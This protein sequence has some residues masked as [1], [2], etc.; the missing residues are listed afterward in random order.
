MKEAFWTTETSPPYRIQPD[1][2]DPQKREL[3]SKVDTL[4]TNKRFDYTFRFDTSTAHLTLVVQDMFLGNLRLQLDTLLFSK[5]VSVSPGGSIAYNLLCR[6]H[7]VN[8]PVNNQ[9]LLLQME[10]DDGKNT[11]PL[12]TLRLRD[13]LA[14]NNGQYHTLAQTIPMSHLQGKQG[15]LRVKF[16]ELRPVISNMVVRPPS[17]ESTLAL[18]GN[19]GM[20]RSL[21]ATQIPAEFALSQNYPNPFNPATTITISL[22][23][24]RKVQL[25]IYD[26]TGRQ[27][28][29]LLEQP[30]PAGVHQ[31][32]WNGR[33]D[34]GGLVS[35]GVYVYRII[36]GD[37]VQSRKMVLMG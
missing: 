2:L 34:K 28:R 10:F 26:I 24:D 19:S 12:R 29:T 25:H 30:L 13:L 3:T 4:I 36:A 11:Y 32:V 20:N 27:L 18:Q 1:N 17:R 15:R 8:F 22:P 31:L 9:L 16:G 14:F 6:F 37:F 7:K 5:P 23:E 35:S 33:N 21:Q